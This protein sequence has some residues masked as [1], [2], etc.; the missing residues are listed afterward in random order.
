[1]E[2]KDSAALEEDLYLKKKSW[3][4]RPFPWIA[5]VVIAAGGSTYA[6]VRQHTTASASPAYQIRWIQASTG[7]VSQAVSFSGTL[8]PT[9]QATVSASGTL[10]SVSVKVGQKVKKGQVLA[11]LDTSSLELQLEQA[12][13]Q[14]SSAQAKL[15]QAQE[16]TTTTVK[17]QT[18]T[19]QPDPNVVAQAQASVDQANANVISIENQISA[20]TITS[21]ISGTIMTVANPNSS[22]STSSSTSSSTGTGSGGGSGSLSGGGSASGNTIAT[23]TDLSS[24]HF[25]VQAS[26]AQADVSQVHPGQQARISLSS[27]GGGFLT[28]KVK[29]VQLIPQ[30]SS[31]VTTY[32]AIIQVDKPTQSGIT[33]LPGA[34]VSVEVT[35]KQAKNVVTVPTAALTQSHGQIGVYEKAGTGGASG[36]G[37]TGGSGGSSASSGANGR[38]GG[39]SSNGSN[40][41][42]SAA[43]TQSAS[44]SN[45]PSGLVFHPVS[46][47]LYGGN[48][49][50]ITSGLKS[51][52]QIA[53]VLPIASQSSGSSSSNGGSGSAFRGIGRLSGGGGFGGGNFN[54]GGTRNSGGSGGGSAS[55]SSSSRTGG[56]N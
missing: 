9:N 41:Q 31:G 1:M 43:K 37:A 16:P 22:T 35:E 55:R 42:S 3:W 8:E 46:V 40:G 14:L 12:K 45:V 11:H 17:G 29:S 36:S 34:S 2:S 15:A 32:P 54:R 20:C 28:G 19:T 13:A 47:G 7:T 50:Q 5:V 39:S 51:G 23:I 30:T 6:I 33:M 4:K 52:Q 25:E 10:K 27:T 49:V 53:L 38:S 21:P 18:Q 24:S 44:T 26:V 48:T 56:G